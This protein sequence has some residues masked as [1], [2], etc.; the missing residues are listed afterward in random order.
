MTNEVAAL[1]LRNNYLQSQRLSVAGNSARPN[2]L[3]EF[4]RAWCARWSAADT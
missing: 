1:V 4:T 2:A 3:T